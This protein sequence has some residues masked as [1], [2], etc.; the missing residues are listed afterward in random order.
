[1][2]RRATCPGYRWTGIDEERLSVS[3]TDCIV[4][5]A[6]DARG[7]KDIFGFDRIFAQRG[8]TI[9]TAEKEAA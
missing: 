9:P 3:L 7:T 5:A 2:S 6:A 4:M 8:Y 1:M